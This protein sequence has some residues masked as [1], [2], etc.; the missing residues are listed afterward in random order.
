MNK[1]ILFLTLGLAILLNSNLKAQEKTILITDST[2]FEVFNGSESI[3]FDNGPRKALMYSAIL[4]GLGQAYNKKY[5][6]MP[7]VYGGFVGMGYMIKFYNDQYVF[8]RADLLNSI[9]DTNYVSPYGLSQSQLRTI[10]EQ[11]RRERDY[12]TILTGVLYLLQIVD[13]HVD[14]HLKEFDNNPDLQV[15]LNP[16][17]A[18][19]GNSAAIGFGISFHF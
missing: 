14:A 16:S 3:T 8:F 17:I 6:K 1:K 9:N 19:V 12:M 4:P 15:K 10:V 2:D 13:A 11:A 18:P 7:I 5:W